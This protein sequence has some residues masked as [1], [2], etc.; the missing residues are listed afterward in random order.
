[1]KSISKGGSIGFEFLI[2]QL[3]VDPKN[4]IKFPKFEGTFDLK[5]RA[6]ANKTNLKSSFINVPIGS[7]TYEFK[8]SGIGYK[9]I[10]IELF[11]GYGD[12]V[13]QINSNNNSCLEFI[14]ME[15]LLGNEINYE[16]FNEVSVS[17]EQDY[18]DGDESFE[19]DHD[20]IVKLSKIDFDET[21]SKVN[22]WSKLVFDAIDD[23]WDDIFTFDDLLNQDRILSYQV[24]GESLDDD[25]LNNLPGATVPDWTSSIPSTSAPPK[26]CWPSA[27]AFRPA[28]R[29][30]PLSP[31]RHGICRATTIRWSWRPAP[32]CRALPSSFPATGPCV[33]PIP[34]SSR[35]V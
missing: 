22:G 14:L 6:L 34:P 3:I 24:K 26:S 18:N 1:M 31:P 7:K 29:W 27:A 12:I 9:S 4:R 32:L 2:G 11:M 17:V 21:I 16:I 28:P 19:V 35:A 23:M 13:K 8:I 30:T 5:Q 33:P 15:L 20:S 25:V 10:K